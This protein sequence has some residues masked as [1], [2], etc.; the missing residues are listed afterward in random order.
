M[1]KKRELLHLHG[2]FMLLADEFIE[3][4]E[5][6]RETLASYHEYDVTPMSLQ[7]TAEAHEKAV[8][9]LGAILA[10]RAKAHTPDSDDTVVPAE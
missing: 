1:M 7:A 5:L 8:L 2:L 6:E 9:E 10:E 3:R 4:G